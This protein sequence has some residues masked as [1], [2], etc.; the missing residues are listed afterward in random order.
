[1]AASPDGGDHWYQMP[2]PVQGDIVL[3]TVSG[4]GV[5]VLAT[6]T[7]QVSLKVYICTV[8]NGQY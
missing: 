2:W 8:N 5:L 3:V 6:D 4:Q 1:M 7:N